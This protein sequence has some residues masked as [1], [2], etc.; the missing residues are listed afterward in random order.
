MTWQLT[1]HGGVV[2]DVKTYMTSDVVHEV[3]AHWVIPKP[4]YDCHVDQSQSVTWHPRGS[5]KLFDMI[6]H[7]I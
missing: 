4:I 7:Q 3:A 1:M 5:Q 6:D 2:V